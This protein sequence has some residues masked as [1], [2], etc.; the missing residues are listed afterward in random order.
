MSNKKSLETLADE[1]K[2]LGLIPN[3]T[4]SYKATGE[5][6]QLKTIATGAG[7]LPGSLMV[8]YCPL[9]NPKVTFVKKIEE[10]KKEFE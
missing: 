6:Y 9:S 2:V 8:V 3:N 7:S 10:F 5:K 1:Q 4:Y